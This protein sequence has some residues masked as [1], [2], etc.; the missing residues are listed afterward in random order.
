MNFFAHQLSDVKSQNIG[1]GTKIWQF[2]TI[3]SGAM[4]GE[5][6][7]ICA[8][9]LIENDVVVGNNVTVKSGVQLW[10]GLRIEDDVFIGPN[11]TFANDLYP[12]SKRYPSKFLGTTIR[13]GASIGANATILPGLSIGAGCIVG[14]GAVVTKDVPPNAIVVGNPA[15]I[16][17][18]AGT[19]KAGIHEDKPS[20]EGAL[21]DLGVGGCAIC[22]LPLIFDLRGNLSVAEYQKNVPFKAERFFWV[23]GVPSGE[24][25]G[26]HAHRVCQQYLICV[27]GSLSVILDDSI[28]RREVLLDKPNLGL[29]IPAGVWGVQYKYS[30]DAVLFVIASDMYDSA[31]YIR[32]YDDFILYKKNS[33]KPE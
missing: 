18:Y 13:H 7:N 9:V 16:V 6:C 32:N 14:A 29:Y 1:F 24:V 19:S 25:R 5:N 26:E 12:R 31:D 22:E 17:G 2:C 30:Q 23:F 21:I 33:A 10:D 27:K 4:I 3:F 8:G 28:K 15:T 20:S 11:A